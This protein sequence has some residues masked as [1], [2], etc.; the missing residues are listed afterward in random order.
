MID[1]SKIP[2]NP[3]CYLYK[4]RE[5]NVIYVGKAK[6]LKKRVASYFQK[7]DHDA[8]TSSLVEHIDSAD[9]FVTD[10]EMVLILETY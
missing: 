4:N 1:L 5:G 6:N 10:N 7:R 2:E 3:G 8:K 9:F